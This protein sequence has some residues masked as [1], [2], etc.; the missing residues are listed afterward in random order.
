M[1]TDSNFSDAATGPSDLGE[2]FAQH[3]ERLRRMVHLRLDRRLN[4]RVDASDVIQDAYLEASRRFEEYERQRDVSPFV[5]LRFLTSQKLAQAHRY[6]LGTQA[7]DAGREVSINAAAGP[8]ASSAALAAQLV[9]R[10]SSPSHAMNRA[11][12]RHRI[13]QALNDMED[14]DREILALRH[15]EH[16]DNAESAEV[17]GIE[18]QA[19]YKR[20]IRAIRR[21][22][23]SLD[24]G[25]NA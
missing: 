21:L 24:A 10:F 23:Q 9:G 3:R 15:F 19:S 22:K 2:L 16:L 12:Q 20:Y 7:R 18:K 1:N 4:G 17:L 5:W 13:Q 11:E 14:V 25:E 6:H 8:E